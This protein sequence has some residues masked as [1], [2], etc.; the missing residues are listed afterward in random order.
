M[1][2]TAQVNDWENP[3]ITQINTEKVHATYVPFR[4]LS[5]SNNALEQSPQVKMLNGIWKFRYFRNPGLIPSGI[6]REHDVSGWD[7]IEVPS[8]WQLQND[9]RYDPPVFT[10][11]KYPFEPNPPFVPSWHFCSTPTPSAPS[12]SA[13][14][15]I[16]WAMAWV[17]SAF[18]FL[19]NRK[20]IFSAEWDSINIPYLN[21]VLLF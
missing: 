3:E 8:N 18:V 11:I 2:A 5:W 9:G 16:P 21:A 13:S 19:G 7:N 14:M 15:R 17:T 4:Q 20:S 12:S 10:N 6:H 1:N